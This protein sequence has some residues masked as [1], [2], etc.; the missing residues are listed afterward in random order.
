MSSRQHAVQRFGSVIGLRA[1][2]EQAYREMHSAVWPE[3]LAQIS[4]SN[5]RNYSIFVHDDVL[6]SYFEYVGDDFRADMASMAADP[7]TRRWWDVMQP[8]QRQLDNTPEGEWWLPMV[9]V[10]HVD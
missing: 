10:F 4:R 5:I 6:F 2:H 7:H 3:V 1:E 9:E 8:M